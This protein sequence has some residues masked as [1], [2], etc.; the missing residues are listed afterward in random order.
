MTTYDAGEENQGF[1]D[2]QPATDVQDLQG[3]STDAQHVQDTQPAADVQ[4]PQPAVNVQAQ[5]PQPPADVHAPQQPADVQAPQPAANVQAQAPQPPADVQAPKPAAV[6]QAPQGGSA[7]V[8]HVQAPKPAAQVQAPLTPTGMPAPGQGDV[9]QNQVRQGVTPVSSIP[10]STFRPIS[11]AAIP[12]TSSA[13]RVMAPVG[14]SAI[15]GPM[16]QAALTMAAP[17]LPSMATMTTT[18][19]VNP[20]DADTTVQVKLVNFCSCMSKMS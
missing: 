3:A 9:Q 17:Q 15:T 1:D 11:P 13:F 10:P 16:L 12:S 4:A 2:F 19:V 8:Q 20:L 7:D 14:T 5:A 18:H 6:G